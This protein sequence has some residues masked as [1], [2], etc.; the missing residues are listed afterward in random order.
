[1][2]FD[3]P[4]YAVPGAEEYESFNEANQSIMDYP[5]H[6]VDL[7]KEDLDIPWSELILKENIGT[8]F[9]FESSCMISTLKNC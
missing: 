5:S 8:G 7:D 3:I 9:V 1:M 2:T 6:E 4:S